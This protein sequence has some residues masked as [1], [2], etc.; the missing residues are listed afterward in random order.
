MTNIIKR[1]YSL[2]LCGILFFSFVSR[3]INVVIPQGY[4]FDE[5]YHAV[6]AKLI[7]RN[8]PRAYEWWN[9]AVEPNTAVDWL[10]PPLAKY[11]QALSILA[12]GENA[13]GWRFSS[14]IFGVLVIFV[15]VKLTDALFKNKTIALLAGLLA[16]LDGLLLVQSRIAMNDI[17]VT[18]FILLTLLLYVKH[19]NTLAEQKQKYTVTRFLVATG[20]TA[21]LAMGS[22]WSGLYVLFPIYLFELAHFQ[23]YI[24]LNA[25]PEKVKFIIS[26]FILLAVM[27]IVV[28]VLCYSHMF[29]QGKS[30][31][32]TQQVS[33]Q[34]KCYYEVVKDFSGN[35]V[36]WEGYVSHFVALHR[37]IWWYQTNLD[38]THPYQSR[39]WQW[40]LNLKPVWFSV[41][42]SDTKRSD[43]YA[44]GN[45][46]LFWIGDVAVIGLLLL[47]MTVLLRNIK[48]QNANIDWKNNHYLKLSLIVIAYFAVW[49]PWQF[50][51]RIMFFYHYTPA[52]PLLCI[53]TASVL[54]HLGKGSALQKKLAIFLI[55]IIVLN[56]I[57]FYPHWTGIFVPIEIKDTLYFVFKS[58]K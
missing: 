14:V 55:S 23:Q 15:T 28:Y 34:G 7:A 21:G 38:A 24:S 41:E 3:I 54:Y 46:A 2:L 50:S 12:F 5:V 58:W 20:I 43:I 27:P 26:R 19:R 42:Y 10:H 51:P 37:Q 47:L 40:F 11:F 9:P 1:Y 33:I 4:V 48:K 6:T 30:F 45:T 56:F 13:L 52:V 22:K 39:P 31:I 44:L 32:C 36:L 29:L 25:K 57:V 53:I 49:L 16:S 17:H 35:T 8:D 18:F